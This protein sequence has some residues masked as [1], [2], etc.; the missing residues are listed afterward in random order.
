MS[1]SPKREV[2][3]ATATKQSLWRRMW[4]RSATLA[5]CYRAVGSR[6][7]TP[8]WCVV[9]LDFQTPEDGTG[10]GNRD[11]TEQTRVKIDPTDPLR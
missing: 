2:Y 4:G 6:T 10:D 8:A 5:S 1:W 3:Q 9:G 7:G 11:T